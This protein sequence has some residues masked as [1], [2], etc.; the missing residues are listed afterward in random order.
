MAET[1]AIEPT[2]TSAAPEAPAAATPTP[3]TATPAAAEARAVRVAKALGDVAAKESAALAKARG[4]DE[5]Y[6]AAEALEA[7]VRPV[8]EALEKRDVMALFGH[9]G[10]TLADV[11]DLINDADSQ[12]ERAASPEEVA[13]R[14]VDEE[15]KRRADEDA[16]AA[17]ERKAKDVE[18]GVA[19]KHAELAKLVQ[20]DPD[21][22]EM[23]DLF[24]DTHELAAAHAW[25]LIEGAYEEHGKVLRLDEA[26]D[27]TEAH[28]LE[29]RGEKLKRSKKLA[30]LLQQKQEPGTKAAGKNDTGG[31]AAT[32]SLN[33]RN[34]SSVAPVNTDEDDDDVPPREA[35][36]RAAARAGI[37]V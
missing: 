2:E 7:K 31:R 32:P 15:L 36:R 34:T 1:A 33:N 20:S 37:Q 11:V 24:F 16:K 29:T 10:V 9:A 6:A 19:R 13:R 12:A 17:A 35:I 21:R 27:L 30:G 26:L 14:T 4:A 23:C 3:A 25:A 28:I 5:R 8:L 18:E 22:F